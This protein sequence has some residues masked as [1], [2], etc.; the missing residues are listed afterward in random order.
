MDTRRQSTDNTPRKVL[1]AHPEAVNCL[2]FHPKHDVLVATGS[3]DKTVAM[4]DLRYLK[5]KV[6]SFEGHKDIVNKLE[7]HPTWPHML[8][9]SSNDRRIIIW[10]ITRV[11]MEQTEEEAEDG[12]PELFVPP[13]P[14][15]AETIR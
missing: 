6:Q 7:W 8:A 10:D 4:W 5:Q 11:G 15:S 3:N 12:P 2:A 9:S 14:F 1:D 13:F